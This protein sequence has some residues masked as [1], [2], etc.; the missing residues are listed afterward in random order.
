MTQLPKPLE[1]I[2]DEK[3]KA[4]ENECWDIE[5]FQDFNNE[6]SFKSGFSAAAEIFLSREE[7]YREALEYTT[8]YYEN[9]MPEG[10]CCSTCDGGDAGYST[11]GSGYHD[12]IEPHICPQ[13][14]ARQVLKELEFKE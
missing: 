6:D 4:H 7:K 14:L 9:P 5:K 12:D 3:A 10:I 2:R 8:K 13:L 11:K 1:K